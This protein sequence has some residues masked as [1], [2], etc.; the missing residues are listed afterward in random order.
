M[1]CPECN[2]DALTQS[3]SIDVDTIYSEE[4]VHGFDCQECGAIVQVTYAPILA[5]GIGHVE[6]K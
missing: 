2:A 5:V 4:C 1:N 6:D 3:E